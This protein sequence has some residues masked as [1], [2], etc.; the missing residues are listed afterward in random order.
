MPV[1]CEGLA[2]D[3]VSALGATPHARCQETDEVIGVNGQQRK[4][5]IHS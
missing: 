1:T 5:Q 3:R 2:G 4:L